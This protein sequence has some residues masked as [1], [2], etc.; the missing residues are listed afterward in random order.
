MENEKLV[1]ALKQGDELAFE[2]LFNRYYKSLVAFI[3][4]YTRNTELSEDIVQ[5]SF[6]LLWNKKED[7]QLKGSPKNYLYTIAYNQFVDQYRKSKRNNDFLEEFRLEFLR[8][9]ID[10]NEELMEKR[11]EKLKTIIEKLPPKCKRILIMS[12]QQGLKYKEI[13]Y[14]LNISPRTVEEQVRIAFKKIRKAFEEDN[15]FLFFMFKK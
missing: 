2:F 10:E 4:T 13:A 3:T 5:Q 15:L 9:S 12:R 7:L 1:T 14:K 8:N 6:I 11:I